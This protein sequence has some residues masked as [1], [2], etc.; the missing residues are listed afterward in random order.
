MIFQKTKKL[1][2][3]TLKEAEDLRKEGAELQ[4]SPDGRILICYKNLKD[5]SETG[6]MDEEREVEIK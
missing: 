2:E 3:M 5:H 4:M 6:H 1:Y